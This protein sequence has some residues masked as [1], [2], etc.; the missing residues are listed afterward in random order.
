MMGVFS[1]LC[2]KK[3]MKKKKTKVK[4]PIR[5]RLKM[6]ADGSQSIYLDKYVKG[7]RSYEFLRLYLVPEIDEESRRLNENALK[8][9]NIIK[10]RRIIEQMNDQAGVSN[11]E[12]KQTTLLKDYIVQYRK[13]CQKIHR[14]NS[15]V[16]NCN[17]M[18]NHLW[19]YLGDRAS[20]LR[21]KDISVELCRGFVDYLRQATTST[22][23]CLSPVSVHHYFSAF[24]SLLATAAADEV[25]P[26][27][28]IEK[29]RRNEIPGR[30][31]VFCEYLDAGEVAMMAITACRNEMVK[32]AFLFSC[33]T[34]LRISDIRA[35]QWENI[36]KSGDTWRLSMVMKKT[37]ES[38]V[39]K[40]SDEAVACLPAKTDNG[41]V[42]QMPT[43][44]SVER[45]IAK[46]A[47]TAGIRKHVTFH[48][49]RH[50]YATMALTA[51]ADLYTI[52][53]LLGHRNISTTT[54]YATVIDAKRDAATDSVGKLFQEHFSRR[55][56]E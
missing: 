22:G 42:F 28:P 41:R 23:R 47:L 8:T 14:G 15:Y 25:I 52:S 9:A 24:R 37:Q 32:R 21:M 2:G 16:T 40:L 29:M 26:S 55:Q 48:T 50:S 49:A 51:G 18:Q 4:E 30:P 54:I 11:D 17:S 1:Y 38:I 6:L 5:I 35:L 33:F 3:V 44:S 36:S 19:G 43:T 13:D 46:W 20:K 12:K 31:V 56:N 27:N 45:T 39:C 7:R 10:A 34:G 53:K